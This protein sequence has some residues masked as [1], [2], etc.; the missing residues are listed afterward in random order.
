MSGGYLNFTSSNQP[1]HYSLS[2]TEEFSKLHQI[3]NFTVQ[4][5]YIV[6]HIQ[7][8]NN[9]NS[10][11]ATFNNISAAI[12]ISL[13]DYFLGYNF[14]LKKSF[15][16][17][18]NKNTFFNSSYEFFPVLSNLIRISCNLSLE[19]YSNL[20]ATSSEIIF[21][22]T[23]IITNYTFNGTISTTNF[24][25]TINKIIKCG[26]GFIIY[27]NEGILNYVIYTENVTNTNQIR[28]RINDSCIDL[29]CSDSYLIC[30]TNNSLIIYYSFSTSFSL[31]ITLNEST[32]SKPVIFTDFYIYL[33]NF[34]GVIINRTF[35]QV[36]DLKLMDHNIILY[37]KYD[38]Y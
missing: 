11:T 33:D 28:N 15:I 17:F 24:L 6:G 5:P 26:E 34:L 23:D 10:Q 30:N 38:F 22:N 19:L 21:Y 2:I 25:F 18:E 12:N 20:L 31:Y 13:A 35:L 8:I 16:L 36:Y 4:R 9:S 37:K 14:N 29:K 3:Q 1:E 7:S 32:Y 27:Y